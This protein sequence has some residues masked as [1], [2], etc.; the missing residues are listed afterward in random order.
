[1]SGDIVWIREAPNPD[2]TRGWL[3][4]CSG[5]EDEGGRVQ[6]TTAAASS[7]RNV[8]VVEL[9]VLPPWEW[10]G[11]SRLR[12]STEVNATLLCGVQVCDEVHSELVWGGGR[13]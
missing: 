2:G 7:P 1:M 13:R 11:M 9:S 12:A 10:A 3:Q 6:A 4:A 5:P 8:D